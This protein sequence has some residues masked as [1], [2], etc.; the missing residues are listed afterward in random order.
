LSRVPEDDQEVLKNDL[1]WCEKNGKMG[2]LVGLNEGWPF[3]RGIYFNED[4][5]F[6][7]HINKAD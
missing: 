4:K 5:S 3:M 1:T 7:A 2:E 6:V